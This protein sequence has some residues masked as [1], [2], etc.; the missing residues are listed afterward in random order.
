MSFAEKAG[1]IDRLSRLLATSIVM[2][3]WLTAAPIATARA[4]TAAP[5]PIRFDGTP[6]E[7]AARREGIAPAT[8][9]CA[10]TDAQRQDGGGR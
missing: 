8:P 4:D 3:A 7:Q 10:G 9:V 6:W 1:I 2:L 5:P